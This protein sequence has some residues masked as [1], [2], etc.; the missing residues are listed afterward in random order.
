[1]QRKL[2]DAQGVVNARN[3]EYR[4]AFAQTRAPAL[5][6]TDDPAGTPTEA[7][8]MVNLSTGYSFAVAGRVNCMFFGADNLLAARFRDATSRI[9]HFA[10]N[11][12]RTF[13]LVYRIML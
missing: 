9:K 6:T 2:Q 7:Y 10:F 11:A 5:A 12:G 1:M 8:D 4:H 13:S 3:T